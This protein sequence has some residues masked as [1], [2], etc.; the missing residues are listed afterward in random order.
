MSNMEHGL[1]ERMAN[2][3]EKSKKKDKQRKNAMN[4]LQICK[5]I[6]VLKICCT[7]RIQIQKFRCKSIERMK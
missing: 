7:V 5:N 1:N 6:L 3:Y 4:F 2:E